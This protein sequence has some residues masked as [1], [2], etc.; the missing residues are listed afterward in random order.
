[1]IDLNIINELKSNKINL[2]E[3]NDEN[4][5]RLLE[6]EKQSY[7]IIENNQVISLIIYKKKIEQAIFIKILKLSHLKDLTLKYTKITEIPKNISELKQLMSL[8]LS[9]NKIKR[10]PKSLL[11]LTFLLNL[12]IDNNPLT[13][14]SWSYQRIKRLLLGIPN[15]IELQFTSFN[16]DF[17][18]DLKESIIKI[19]SFDFFDDMEQQIN[20]L[21]YLQDEHIDLWEANVIRTIMRSDLLNSNAILDEKKFYKI[22]END[23]EAKEKYRKII[24]YLIQFE[25]AFELNE[26]EVLI[27]SKL[28]MQLS[29]Y[30][31]ELAQYKLSFCYKY[32]N[33]R[34]S[35]IYQFIIK[36]KNDVD[37]NLEETRF[38]NGVIL[39]YKDCKAI[40]VLEKKENI[41]LIAIDKDNREGL[42]F[43]SNIRREFEEINK[44][45]EFEELVPIFNDKGKISDYRDIS[46]FDNFEI[47]STIPLIITEGKTDWRHLKKA[48]ERFQIIYG[49]YIDLNIQFEEYHDIG[50][51]EST[52]DSWLK[53]TAKLK[54]EQRHIFMFD[55]DTSKYVEEYGKKEFIRVLDKD[56]LNRLK[57]KLEK[58]YGDKSSTKYLNIEE[59]LDEGLYQKADEEIKKVFTGDEYNEWEK[60]SH[61]QVYALCIPEIKNSDSPRTLDK[62]CIEFYYKEKDLKTTKDGKRLFFADE[63]EFNKE[64]KGD[65]SKRFISKCSKFKTS[66]RKVKKG[67]TAELTLIS[68]PVYSIDD[69]QC[70]NNLL[71]SKNDFTKYIENEVEGFDDFDIENFRLIF[72]VIEKIVKD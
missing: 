49:E 66:S 39:T 51:G 10:I 3:A 13:I 70:K 17:E 30:D 56:Y 27:P 21:L 1:M 54:Q 61:N 16:F 58:H 24:N 38:K 57:E 43:L 32:Q 9:N 2:I 4:I 46:L 59:Y 11:E 55:R 18:K 62:I 40:V 12:N 68:T 8:D 47:T 25:L 37:S 22:F 41:I 60:L 7:Y 15:F 6:Q 52:I 35:L 19:I 63:F 34:N 14:Q 71:L 67:A 45:I 64:N 69:E 26:N 5:K 23:N 29:E 48:L 44:S 20:F 50:A 53:S 72:D 65:N 33:I 28:P 42:E 31:T 36:M